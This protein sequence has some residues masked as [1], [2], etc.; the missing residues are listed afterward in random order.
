[1]AIPFQVV[2]EVSQVDGIN[3]VLFAKDDGYK[4]F[5]PGNGFIFYSIFCL[6][7]LIR[8]QKIKKVGA[9]VGKKMKK[10]K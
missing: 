2:A 4:G 7:L 10:R 5:I 9:A 8:D 1:M 6:I 3:R